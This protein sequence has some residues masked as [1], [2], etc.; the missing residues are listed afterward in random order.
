MQAQKDAIFFAHSFEKETT[1]WSKV[2]DSEVVAWFEKLLAKRWRVVSGKGPEARAIQDKVFDA[3]NDTRALVS[4]FTRRYQVANST[5]SYL[6]SP[7]LLCECALALGMFR[8]H[9]HHVVAG[10]REKGISLDSLGMLATGMEYPEFDRENLERDRPIFNKYLDDLERRIKSGPTG[11]GSI[12]P[13]TYAQSQLHKIYLIY[14]NGFGTVHNIVDIVIKDADRFTHELHGTVPHRLWTHFGSIPPLSE[15]LRVPVHMRKNKAFFHGILDTHKNRRVHSQLEVKEESR[16][17][18]SVRFSI[19]FQE[20]DGQPLRVKVNDTLRYQ[21]AWGLPQMF[22]VNEEELPDISG[23]L[24]TSKTYCLAEL[25]ANYGSIDRARLELRFE[26]E[27]RD[28]HESQLFSK[29]PFV[30]FGRGPAGDTDWGQPRQVKIL[31]GDPDEFD[32]WYERYVVEAKEFGKRVA[33]A[34]R[35]SSS[36]H[37]L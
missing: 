12:D 25:D 7:W 4:L 24:I 17:G 10:F 29:S 11:Q 20:P 27:A 9:D 1:P 18:T 3:V 33:V 37:Q 5:T 6:T 30:R 2:T 23:D 14:R 26:R 34:W 19:R 36:K 35:P 8:N 31:S 13:D 32:M 22:P 15:M 28:G 16:R 21:Y